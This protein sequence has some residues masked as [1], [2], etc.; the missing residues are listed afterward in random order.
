[1]SIGAHDVFALVVNFINANWQLNQIIIGLFG[2]IEITSQAMAM[3]LQALLDNYNLWKKIL[4]YVKDEGS[5][6]GAMTTI[7]KSVVS[8]DNLRLEE[9]FQGTYFGH[10]MSKAC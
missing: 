1:M 2:A 9:P 5:N 3:K 10:T 8:C 7:L 4:V 6:V